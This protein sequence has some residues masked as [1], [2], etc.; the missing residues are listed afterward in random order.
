MLASRTRREEALAREQ[1]D[2]V[3][4]SGDQVRQ[5]RRRD[6]GVAVFRDRRVEDPPY[7]KWRGAA[8]PRS[9]AGSFGPGT[10]KSIEPLVSSTIADAMLV[11]SRNCFV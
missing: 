7:M 6:D 9:Q 5:R 1:A 4:L 10:G 8:A 3:P 2:G 11:V